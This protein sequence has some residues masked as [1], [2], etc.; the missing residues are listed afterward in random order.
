M[1]PVSRMTGHKYVDVWPRRWVRSLFWP[2]Q[3]WP[4]FSS[5]GCWLFSI[6]KSLLSM[7][8]STNL[9]K[10]IYFVN[11]ISFFLISVQPGAPI[12]E[13]VLNRACI[14]DPR[15]GLGCRQLIWEVILGSQGESAG[16]GTGKKGKSIRMH[17]I[18]LT[19]TVGNCSPVSLGCLQGTMLRRTSAGWGL[20][21]KC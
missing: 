19:T 14:L 21:Q 11:N 2:K 6:Q 8:S 10:I 9:R 1:S 20:P 5:N 17:F 13:I 3:W 15:Q 7:S 16:S 12:P 4:H 18:E